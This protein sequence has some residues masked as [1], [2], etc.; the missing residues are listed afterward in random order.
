MPIAWTNPNQRLMAS[1]ISVDSAI[2]K[3][4]L[5]DG[6]LMASLISVDSAIPKAVLK[7]AKG[8]VIITRICGG[9]LHV[10]GGFGSG[11][12]LRRLDDTH[13]SGPVSVNT[14][15]LNMGLMMGMR[16]SDTLLCLLDDA[17]INVSATPCL[18]MAC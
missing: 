10:G 4:V 9:F 16:K 8:L 14:I 5:P 18:L 2:P 15:S 7:R 17:A 11:I 3:A 12:M 13:W 6:M 1:L